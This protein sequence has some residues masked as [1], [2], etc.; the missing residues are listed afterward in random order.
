MKYGC[1]IKVK[2]SNSQILK[3]MTATYTMLWDFHWSYSFKKFEH[4]VPIVVFPNLNSS[5]QMLKIRFMAIFQFA[6]GHD[7]GNS[8]KQPPHRFLFAIGA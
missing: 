3:S 1:R 2:I 7:I 4:T 8:S 5:V 6:Q